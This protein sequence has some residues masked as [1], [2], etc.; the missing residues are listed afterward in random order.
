MYISIMKTE[1]LNLCDSGFL[2]RFEGAGTKFVPAIDTF[3][4]SIAGTKEGGRVCTQCKV[5]VEF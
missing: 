5:R 2:L 1:F 3:N 4:V